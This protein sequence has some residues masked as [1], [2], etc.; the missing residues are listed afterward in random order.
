VGG[1]PALAAVIFDAGL[2]LVQAVTPADDVAIGVLDAAGIAYRPDEVAAAMA[3]AEADLTSRWHHGDW[4]A[5]E[6]T[7][8]GLF[9]SAYRL[10]LGRLA[11]VGGDEALADRLAHGIYDAYQDTRHWALYPDVLPTL[12]SL[13]GAGVPMGIISDW[14]HGLE[15]IVLELELAAYLEFLVVSSRL[16]VAKPDPAVFQM[17]LARIGAAPEGAVYVG[18]TYLKDV[19][20]A[21][22]AGLYPVLLDRAGQQPA[23]DCSRIRSLVE[24]L[25]LLGLAPAKPPPQPAGA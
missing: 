3:A 11:A 17:A 21:R 12:A 4:W 2:T 8:R 5:R 9:V 15:A 24:L 22:A 20:G 10:G 16:G 13:R 1:D 25:P 6:A 19:L 14:G 7:V 18:D 23:P